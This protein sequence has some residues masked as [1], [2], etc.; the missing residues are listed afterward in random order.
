[1]VMC[2]VLSAKCDVRCAKVAIPTALSTEHISTFSM[3]QHEEPAPPDLAE[4]A[5]VLVDR[6]PDEKCLTHNVILGNKSPVTR[7]QGV[8]AVVTH[9]EIVILSEGVG[10]NFLS[11]DIQLVVLNLDIFVIVVQLDNV[12]IEG[13]S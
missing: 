5:G 13:Q 2:Y 12:T 9:H 4:E 7:I 10:G 8:V 1:M 3:Y 11:V 6:Q